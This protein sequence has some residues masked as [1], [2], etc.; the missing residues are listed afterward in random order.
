MRID[1]M[2]PGDLLMVRGAANNRWIAAKFIQQDRYTRFVLAS[3]DD[4]PEGCWYTPSCCAEV[5]IDI[6]NEPS[7]TVYVCPTCG[8]TMRTIKES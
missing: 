6:G 8:G 3:T 5:G 7:R 1:D 2:K 4:H